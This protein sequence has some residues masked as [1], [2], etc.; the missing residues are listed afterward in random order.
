MYFVLQIHEVE[1]IQQ[2][3]IIKP[4]KIPHH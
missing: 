1:L 3:R 2:I 4:V